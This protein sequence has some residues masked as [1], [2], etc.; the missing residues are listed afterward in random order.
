MSVRT[1][2]VADKNMT[3]ATFEPAITWDFRRCWDI[4]ASTYM[5]LLGQDGASWARMS[6]MHLH[7][8]GRGQGWLD[9]GGCLGNSV[10]MQDHAH[11]DPKVVEG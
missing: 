2:G 8:G 6:E 10:W 7:T 4:G 11:S 3:E 1:I 5:A 9:F